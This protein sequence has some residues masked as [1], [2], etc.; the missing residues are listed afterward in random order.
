MTNVIEGKFGTF[1]PKEELV[2]ECPFCNAG[3]TFYICQDK[4]VVQCVA[5]SSRQFVPDD[6]LDIEESNDE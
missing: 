5:C 2:Y 6:W 3:R 4:G 1:K